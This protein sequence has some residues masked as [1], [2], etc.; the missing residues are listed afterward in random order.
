M[1]KKSFPPP[2][3]K[4]N[5][6]KAPW[7]FPLAER[8]TKS[9]PPRRSG[10]GLSTLHTKYSLKKKTSPPTSHHPHPGRKL[11]CQTLRGMVCSRQHRPD[12]WTEGRRGRMT[13]RTDLGVASFLRAT[14]SALIVCSKSGIKA[15]VPASTLCP[16]LR[17]RVTVPASTVCPESGEASFF[18]YYI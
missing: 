1:E 11:Q 8:K 9:S 12:G 3:L 2:K 6:S 17:V 13:R 5:K 15:M 16:E 18:L 10:H 14:V 7:A 4:R